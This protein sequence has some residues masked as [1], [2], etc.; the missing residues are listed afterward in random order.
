[1]NVRGMHCKSCSQLIEGEIGD[2]KGVESVTVDLAS[3]KA[4]VKFN[5]KEINPRAIKSKITALGYSTG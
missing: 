2:L 4:A 3:G 1:M 5:Q